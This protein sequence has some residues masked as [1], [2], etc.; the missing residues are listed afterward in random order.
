MAIG[1]SWRV[2]VDADLVPGVGDLL[3]LIGKGLDRMA[4]DEPRR[5]DAEPAEELEQPQRADLAGEEAARDV[6]G[7]VLAAIRAE[8]AGHGVHINSEPAQDFLRHRR[9]A[10]LS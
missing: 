3:H 2:A 1:F 5:L 4:G 10:L 9:L 8:P 7:Q 6:V